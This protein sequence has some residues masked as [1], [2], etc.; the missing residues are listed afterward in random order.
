MWTGM[1]Q[2]QLT[3]STDT[4]ICDTI[5]KFKAFFYTFAKF[6]SYSFSHIFTRDLK[7]QK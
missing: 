3:L 1:E 4:Y 5:I 6:T 7:P 2:D